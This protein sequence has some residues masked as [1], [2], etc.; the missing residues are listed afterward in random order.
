MLEGAG[1]LEKNPLYFTPP[2]C[3]SVRLG[4]Y[5]SEKFVVASVVSVPWLQVNKRRVS[6]FWSR[7]CVARM[8]SRPDRTMLNPVEKVARREIDNMPSTAAPI[9]TSGNEYAP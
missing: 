2:D 6:I 3:V 5:Q 9:T 4:S 8:F 7:I 1:E